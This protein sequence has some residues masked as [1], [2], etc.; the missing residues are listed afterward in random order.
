MQVCAS[1][2]LGVH[3]VPILAHSDLW[4]HVAPREPSDH[5]VDWRGGFT[6]D[7][8]ALDLFRPQTALNSLLKHWSKD[9]SDP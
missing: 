6:W 5:V 8:Q 7:E 2:S 1:V 9:W 4:E 3:N